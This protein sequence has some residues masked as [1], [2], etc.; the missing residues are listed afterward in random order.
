VCS[1]ADTSSI[2]FGRLYPCQSTSQVHEARPHYFSTHGCSAGSTVA[3]SAFLPVGARGVK[4]EDMMVGGDLLE[5]ARRVP[6]TNA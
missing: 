2:V 3:F 1:C 4:K 5:L 6:V